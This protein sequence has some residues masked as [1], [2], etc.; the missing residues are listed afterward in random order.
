[1]IIS[2]QE[3]PEETK[4]AV[5]VKFAVKYSSSKDGLRLETHGSWATRGSGG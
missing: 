3:D 5:G 4:P 1:M 2:R